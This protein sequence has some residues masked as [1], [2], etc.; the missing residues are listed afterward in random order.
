MD[1]RIKLLRDHL[2]TFLVENRALYGVLSKGIHDL[3]EQECLEYFPVVR[4]GI[5]I[6]L[7]EQLER[8]KRETKLATARKALESVGQKLKGRGL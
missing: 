3:R 5:E 1:E 6:I 8:V 2:P 7:D 4:V